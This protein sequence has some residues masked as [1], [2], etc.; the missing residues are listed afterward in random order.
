M[1]LVRGTANAV[2]APIRL[3]SRNRSVAS[4]TCAKTDSVR[5]LKS[6]IISAFDLLSGALESGA[7]DADEFGGG[8]SSRAFLSAGSGLDSTSESCGGPSFISSKREFFAPGCGTDEGGSDFNCGGVAVGFDV[9]LGVGVGVLRGV[10]DGVAVDLAVGV[11]LD[12][13]IAV[14]S[15]VGVGVRAGGGLAVGGGDGDAVG[16]GVDR[17]VKDREGDRTGIGVG[18]MSASSVGGGVSTGLGDSSFGSGVGVAVGVGVRVSVDPGSDQSPTFS[19]FE[20]FAC[21]RVPA[22]SFTTIPSNFPSTILPV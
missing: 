16:V 10:G 9:D 21:K 2:T 4:R 5:C 1:L 12:V 7:F 3:T 6:A 8:A 15:G 19:P 13:G 17:G 18:K 22:C 20:N 11:G 14:A